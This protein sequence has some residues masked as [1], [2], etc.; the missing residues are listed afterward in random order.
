MVFLPNQIGLQVAIATIVH[1][2]QPSNFFRPPRIPN[3]PALS[4]R[5]PSPF[6][7]ASRM[8]R[9][10]LN[11]PSLGASVRALGGHIGIHPPKLLAV[12]VQLPINLDRTRSCMLTL[13]AAA[14][15]GFNSTGT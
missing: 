14:T 5:L 4:M 12:A 10:W 13:P 9:A 8:E 7:P 6:G 2:L 11:G 15:L 1:A 3:Q